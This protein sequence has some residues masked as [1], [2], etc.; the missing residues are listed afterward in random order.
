MDVFVPQVK[1]RLLQGLT[2][3]FGDKHAAG[4]VIEVSPDVGRRMVEARQAAPLDSRHAPA[5]SRRLAIS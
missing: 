5:S 4:D 2:L 3:A 1:V